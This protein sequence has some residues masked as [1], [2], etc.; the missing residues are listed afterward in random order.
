MIWQAFVDVDCHSD[1]SYDL[2][3][4]ASFAG[5]M[6]ARVTRTLGW[7]HQ[8]Q[9]DCRLRRVSWVQEP[10]MEADAELVFGSTNN[11]VVRV[12]ILGKDRGVCYPAPLDLPILRAGTALLWRLQCSGLDGRATFT[13]DFE[14]V[15]V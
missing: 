14:S 15:H 11:T 12:A 7:P 6:K 10:G 1:F 4:Y 8:I 3:L 2:P 9:M 13:F 5:A